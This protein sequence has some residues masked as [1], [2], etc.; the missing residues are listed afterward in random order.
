[1]TGV[2]LSVAKVGPVGLK[3]GV[4]RPLGA[5]FAAFAGEDQGS[6]IAESLVVAERGAVGDSRRSISRA[7]PPSFHWK[8]TGMSNASPSLRQ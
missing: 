2:F 8:R 3:D 7:K 1:M 4:A 5:F 6:G